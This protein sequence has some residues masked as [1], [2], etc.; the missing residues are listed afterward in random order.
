MT[1]KCIKWAAGR[2]YGFIAPDDGSE[3]LFVHQSE[4]KAQG[5]RSLQ[6][7]FYFFIHFYY[8]MNNFFTREQNYNFNLFIKIYINKN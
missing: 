4:I 2:G 7:V 3:D 6:E 1:G 8:I 5:F